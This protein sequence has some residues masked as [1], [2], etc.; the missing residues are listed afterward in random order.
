MNFFGNG[1]RFG[2]NIRYSKE[3]QPL[4]TAGGLGFIKDDLKDTFLMI[5]GDTL[6]TLNYSD[7]INYHK[8]NSTKATI[9]L[10]KR[11]V[12]IDFGT[13]EVDKFNN[14]KEYVEK[15]TIYYLVSMGVYAFEPTVLEYINP[16]EKLDSDELIKMMISRGNGVKGFIFDGHWLDIGRPDDYERANE[17][18][19]QIN[20]ELNNREQPFFG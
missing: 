18:I 8:N 19:A 4:G 16:G 5:N 7:F 13:V 10:K 3:D 6:T 1:S 9:A 2:V 14:V 11:D 12:Y 17:Q 15:P 20:R